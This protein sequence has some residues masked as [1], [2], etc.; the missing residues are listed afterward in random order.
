[1]ELLEKIER[2]CVV[3]EKQQRVLLQV[4]TSGEGVKQGFSPDEFR[5]FA[6]DFDP[7][8]FPHVR[9]EGLMTMAP[10][11]DDE[12]VL[13]ETFSALRE[14]RDEANETHGSGWDQLS[15]G[16][17]NDYRIALEEGA[18]IVRLGTVVFS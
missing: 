4:N 12:A 8:D 10:F 3:A 17:S 2:S 18:T 15:M 6:S 9:I 14:L 13:R 16:M 11:V 5:E 7:N 1:M